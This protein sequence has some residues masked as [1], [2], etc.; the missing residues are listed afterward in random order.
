VKLTLSTQQKVLLV[1]A[2]TFAQT[3]LH[4]LL[5]G[6]GWLQAFTIAI[7]SEGAALSGHGFRDTISMPPSGG[8][9]AS[10]GT[11]SEPAMVIPNK[12]SNPPPA[13]AFGRMHPMMKMSLI[14]GMV[15]ALFLGLATFVSGCTPAQAANDI[16][17]G[18][19][20]LDTVFNDIERRGMTDAQAVADTIAVCGTDL[21]TVV[22]TRQQAAQAATKRRMQ[23]HLPPLDG[24]LADVGQ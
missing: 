1:G 16:V 19:C 13:V 11:P 24:G 20:I 23:L 10:L 15:A 2:L 5:G 22:A 4:A 17:L 21:A 7:T 6:C 18:E 3:A 9:I 14:F 8:V 12:P